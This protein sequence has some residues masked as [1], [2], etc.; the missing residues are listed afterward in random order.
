MQNLIVKRGTL[1][2]PRKNP[3]SRARVA[4]RQ[5]DTFP[6][7]A[8]SDLEVQALVASGVLGVPAA[9]PAELP[10]QGLPPRMGKWCHSPSEL[11]GLSLEALLVLVAQT[12]PDHA[13]LSGAATEAELVRILT[14]DYDPLFESRAPRAADDTRPEIPRAARKRAAK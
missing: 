9:A 6:A 8:L 10:Q 4:L 2:L 11:A 14:A 5:G 12:D 1:M 13:A 3:G 7:G